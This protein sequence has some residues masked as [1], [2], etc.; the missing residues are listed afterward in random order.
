[1]AI[2][3]AG[4]SSTQSTRPIRIAAG[5]L[6]YR[7]CRLA[8]AR[9]YAPMLVSGSGTSSAWQKPNPTPQNRALPRRSGTS[10]NLF[11]R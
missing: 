4:P 11:G 10:S 5:T 3:H 8:T 7:S 9:Q 2:G 1:M 6:M